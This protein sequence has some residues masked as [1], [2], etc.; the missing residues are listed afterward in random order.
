MGAAIVTSAV[1]EM[2]I[3]DDV[4]DTSVEISE[5]FPKIVEDSEKSVSEFLREI[6]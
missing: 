4:G 6:L 5:L 1:E 3:S 2:T